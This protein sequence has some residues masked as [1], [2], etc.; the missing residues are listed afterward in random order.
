MLNMYSFKYCWII[1]PL[2]LSV[3]YIDWMKRELNFSNNWKA[4]CSE[5]IQVAG[6]YIGLSIG[7]LV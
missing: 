4:T 2:T 3:D 7:M 6:V 1:V 5:L